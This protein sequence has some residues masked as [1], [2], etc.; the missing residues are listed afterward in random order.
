MNNDHANARTRLLLSVL[1]LLLA[2]PLTLLFWDVARDAIAVP[3]LYLL[4]IGDL[5]FR[6]V[7]QLFLWIV[8]LAIAL[9]FVLRSLRKQKRPVRER[10]VAET[11]ST[12]QVWTWARRIYLMER[13][14]Y[15]GWYFAR[16][17]QRLTLE[18]LAHRERV[19]VRQIKQRLRTGELDVP[20]ELEACLGIDPG[21]AFS[22]P[23]LSARLRRLL[24][25][26]TETETRT[27]P[28]DLDLEGILQ[29]LEDQ[30]KIGD[31]I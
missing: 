5:I 17:L 28:P 7:P 19:E 31:Q 4:W 9:L 15:S 6:A 30:L 26:G 14:S 27:A 3:L 16:H 18:V 21:R 2:I 24:R 29:F 22:K 10:R 23:S 20:P 12:G 25:L 8:F 1:V 11:P 13:R